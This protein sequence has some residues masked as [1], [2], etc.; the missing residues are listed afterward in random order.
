LCVS[1]Q[2]GEIMTAWVRKRRD[3]RV[4]SLCNPTLTLSWLLPHGIEPVLLGRIQGFHTGG[5]IPDSKD[6]FV[7]VGEEEVDV[8]GD[9]G[10]FLHDGGIGVDE[11]RAGE[12]VGVG[13]RGF[14]R[15]LDAVDRG[16]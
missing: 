3:C 15:W 14:F 8:A 5:E 12:G 2:N 16:L 4:F 7:D 11:E 6:F 13:F 1:L 9:L 10:F